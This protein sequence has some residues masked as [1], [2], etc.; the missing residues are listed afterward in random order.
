MSLPHSPIDFGLPIASTSRATRSPSPTDIQIEELSQSRNPLEPQSESWNTFVPFPDPEFITPPP[1][2]ISVTIIPPIDTNLGQNP[3]DWRK[4]KE[5]EFSLSEPP[6]TSTDSIL[7]YRTNMT[8]EIRNDTSKAK[9]VRLNPPKE[10]TGKRDDLKKFIQKCNLYLSVNEEVYNTDNKRIAFMLSYMTGND[11]EAWA[12]QFTE[13]HT[14]TFPINL[15]TYTN[16]TLLLHEAF[17]PYDTPGDA[18]EDMKELR[19]DSSKDS[20]DEHIAKFKILL[21]SSK[22]DKD[23]LAVIDMFRSTLPIPL[24][25]KLL[26]AERPPRTFDEWCTRASISHNNWVRMKKITARTRMKNENGKKKEN[27]SSQQ[28][29]WTF[30]KKDPN[31]MDIDALTTEKRAEYMKK[32]LCFICGRQG[33][34]ASEH[35]KDDK[36]MTTTTTNVIASSSQQRKMNGKELH[37]HIRALAAQMDE[38]EKD[39]FLKEA[40]EQGF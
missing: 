27:E 14:T 24:Q 4:R 7:S 5:K 33:H 1:I 31:A 18:L 3:I 19:M 11:A 34:R 22:L 32:G 12:S 35:L 30:S 2:N 38:G 9:E 25:S 20:I 13:A 40:E 23:S 6:K 39:T 10:F 29:K 26:D 28:K 15:G 37:A 8:E 17:D 36:K 16:F 21:S